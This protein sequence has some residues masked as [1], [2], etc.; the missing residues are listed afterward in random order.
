MAETPQR[1]DDSLGRAAAGTAAGHH[2]A[3]PRVVA[4]SP[5]RPS[6][7]RADQ[8]PG[9]GAGG[10]AHRLGSWGSSVLARS[11]RAPAEARRFVGD[12][13]AAWGVTDERA[14]IL[15]GVSELVSNAVVPGRGPIEVWVGLRSSTVRVEIRDQGGGGAPAL[16]RVAP[17]ADQPGGRGLRMLDALADSWGSERAEAGGI[18]VWFQR[19]VPRPA[20]S[21]ER[22][23][24]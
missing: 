17:R 16:S 15:L 6:R 23:G 2:G 12:V 19:S 9:V 18:L 13:L 21:T 24:S 5:L 14:D 7:L 4:P 3:A 1:D 22:P 8:P 20:L 11:A 10:G